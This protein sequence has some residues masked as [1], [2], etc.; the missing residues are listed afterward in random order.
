MSV[1]PFKIDVSQEILDDLQRRLANTRWPG[2]IEDAG[3]DYGTDL[4]YLKELCAYWLNGFDWRQQQALLN[5]L[6]HFKTKVEGLNLHFIHERGKG[7]DPLP[8]VLTH[9]WPDSFF[10]FIKIIPLLT[11]PAAYG[12]DPA[13]SFDV[14]VPSMPGF[15]FSDLHLR[16]A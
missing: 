11:D 14:V 10:R 5:R 12:G 4:A 7:P 2:K 8:L 13:D 9:G 3:W 6:A 1:Q 16:K 15:G